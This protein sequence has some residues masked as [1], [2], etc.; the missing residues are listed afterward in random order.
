MA[1]PN[2]EKLSDSRGA[3]IIDRATNFRWQQAKNWH[4]FPQFSFKQIQL[5]IS[6]IIL[7]LYQ[8][9]R[10][11]WPA[12]ILNFCAVSNQ[13]RKICLFVAVGQMTGIILSNS[14]SRGINAG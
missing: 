13:R 9:R 10:Y 12:G 5:H 8:Q 11:P 4:P 14:S 1:W 7:G 6:G 3:Q 2:L